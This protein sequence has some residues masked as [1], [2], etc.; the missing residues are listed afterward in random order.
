M[1]NLT[2]TIRNIGFDFQGRNRWPDSPSSLDLYWTHDT[3]RSLNYGP[4]HSILANFDSS[5]KGGAG[6]E[7]I[8]VGTEDQRLIALQVDKFPNIATELWTYFTGAPWEEK[9]PIF[10][11]LSP[12]GSVVHLNFVRDESQSG[13][14]NHDLSSP[15]S[16][17]IN[18]ST[19]AFITKWSVQDTPDNDNWTGLIQNVA[20]SP[21]S[22][23]EFA[24]NSPF[25]NGPDGALY[26]S[27][28]EADNMGIGFDDDFNQFHKLSFENETMSTIWSKQMIPFD[29]VSQQQ[30][31]I[32]C[33]AF[34]PDTK[35]DGPGD[36][37]PGEQYY[38]M[39]FAHRTSRD[40]FPSQTRRILFRIKTY[41]NELIDPVETQKILLEYAPRGIIFKKE[42]GSEPPRLYV[43]G[44][45]DFGGTAGE[46]G[47]YVYNVSGS[48][49]SE[50]D[51]F[52]STAAGNCES[53][54]SLAVDG[55]IY[56]RVEKKLFAITDDGSGSNPFSE[57]WTFNNLPETNGTHTN[58]GGAT[59]DPKHYAT[60][61]I[62]SSGRIIVCSDTT[63]A[64]NVH[65]F[66]D[67]ETFAELEDSTQIAEGI[68]TT[69]TIGQNSLLYVVG[70][71]KVYALGTPVSPESSS[72]TSSESEVLSTSSETIAST[73]SASS[74]TSETSEPTTTTTTTPAPLQE[75]LTTFFASVEDISEDVK[76]ETVT[77]LGGE[78]AVVQRSCA[79][80][81]IETLNT[82]F[83]KSSSFGT[84][85]PGETSK[86]IIVNLKIPHVRG[87]T[88]I[89]L[90]LIE[91]EGVE[92]GNDIF[93]ITTNANLRD[94][95][96][97]DSFFQG[98]NTDDSPTN[99][100]NV[101]IAN[102]DNNTSEFVY[103]NLNL[104]QDTI[105]N[106]GVIRFKW[107]FDYAE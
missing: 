41:L 62:D 3:G 9:L 98:L 5:L 21:T 68:R 71:S 16:H 67:Q 26:I 47:L 49:L 53:G 84:I 92:F 65:I 19:G 7:I 107:Y 25:H 78:F 48:S 99:P 85:A 60:P 14:G 29:S 44:K 93:G 11:S 31:I 87:I 13:P 50:I 37:N 17:T 52:N 15:F 18:S 95:I 64:A 89:K 30:G 97:P 83:A 45:E 61:I 63:T 81:N 4:R 70:D 101:D 28:V 96:V 1:S 86:N 33:M 43:T 102:V 103:L 24:S 73:S 32:S 23:D 66:S 8:Y 74:S 36:E 79:S 10:P 39:Y 59:L 51:R 77:T 6:D 82:P 27:T 94:D 54:P 46:G 72:S 34:D 104:P 20:H 40:Q 42:A 2:P 69:P 38:D 90:A 57:K 88:N 58:P 80:D 76:E 75:V 100:N 12:D 22:D 106:P 56:F 91:L 55:T 105:I 35:T